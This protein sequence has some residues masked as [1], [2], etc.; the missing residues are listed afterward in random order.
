MNKRSGAT[1]IGCR[2]F[3]IAYNINLNTRDHRLAT[4]IA[5]E[6]RNWQKQKDTTPNSKN[7]LDGDIVRQENGKPNK[8]P[9][10]LRI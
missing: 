2:D 4:D 10:F 6:L 1:I 8:V 5:F 7:L 9:G 3:L